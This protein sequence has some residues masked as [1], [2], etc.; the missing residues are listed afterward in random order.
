MPSADAPAQSGSSP[1]VMALCP[2]C[3]TPF[4][5]PCAEAACRDCGRALIRDDGLVD[6]LQRPP[7]TF[8][9]FPPGAI[10][11]A[12]KVHAGNTDGALSKLLHA[13]P[14][15][16]RLGEYVTGTGRSGWHLL[17]PEGP[18]RTLLDLGC[19]WGPVS[20]NLAPHFANVVAADT[21]AERIA[22][23]AAR[24][25]AEGT[26]NIITV[27]AGDGSRLP[28]PDGQFDV[29]V[30]SG[31]FE[32]VPCGRAGKPEEVQKNLLREIRRV[33]RPGGC[34]AMSIENRWAWKTWATHPD[35]HTGLRFV[36][37][38]PRPLA[39]LWSK[40]KGRGPF[41]NYLYSARQLR[42]MLA[43]AGFPLQSLHVPLPGYHF[44]QAM[45][46]HGSEGVRRFFLRPRA[47]LV[48]RM[49]SALKG[50]L[51]VRW[52]DAFFVR[53]YDA[54]TR[55]VID[56]ISD[57]LSKAG[58]AVSAERPPSYRINGEMA[59][60][61]LM[62]PG[63][64]VV[65]VPLNPMARL[66]LDAEQGLLTRLGGEAV[67]GSLV[68][69]P[70]LCGEAEGNYFSVRSCLP[71]VSASTLSGAAPEMPR[72][73]RDA[74]GF[75][76]RLG[77]VSFPDE[78]VTI[79]SELNRMVDA[80]HRLAWTEVQ[81]EL[82][83]KAGA[84]IRSGLS[85]LGVVPGHGDFKLAN[86]L[87]GRSEGSSVLCGVLDW[88]AAFRPECLGYDLSFLA[89]DWYARV[90]EKGLPAALE[91]FWRA[92]FPADGAW[93]G[94]V[95]EYVARSSG[96]QGRLDVQMLAAWQWFRRLSPVWTRREAA[97]FDFQALEKM[98]DVAG[99]CLQ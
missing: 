2:T 45:E 95:D 43:G 48:R 27:L 15:V 14:S 81:R 80:V 4:A 25:Q 65:K 74:A 7:S 46:P 34:L 89:V 67:L 42:R 3:H 21:S 53:G 73:L 24:A 83:T 23:L 39:G 37:W 93:C 61:T 75:L 31:V 33:L 88:G 55:P 63:G 94:V 54:D 26:Q 72:L 5:L 35:G 77:A 86:L 51:S 57:A 22:F 38:L 84:L 32:W 66:E 71:G 92:G 9:E 99:R 87:A 70:L 13:Y 98:F 96:S 36:A 76:A 78:S 12:L 47:A 85:G 91:R 40:L 20:F 59:V 29:V 6:L 79:D 60:V 11:E 8:S 68:P 10:R 16:P 82:V 64:P 44:P 49:R 50:L 56:A 30:M 97:R 28:F 18:G 90:G 52:P 62:F 17:L 69:R 19:G 1:R 41:R 58:L